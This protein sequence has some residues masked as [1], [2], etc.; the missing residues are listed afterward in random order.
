MANEARVN[1]SLQINKGNLQ[2]RSNPTTFQATITGA[3]GPVPGAI[4]AAVLGT[5][6]NFS[7]LTTPGLCR[8]TNLDAINFVTF[9]VYDGTSFYPLGEILPGEFYVLRLSRDLNE[10]YIGTGTNADANQFRVVA[11]TAA[12]NVLVEAFE[13]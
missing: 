9:G 7:E 4:T 11:N 13:K 12:C 3:K 5:N 8:I 2:F 6:V 10:E 1:S